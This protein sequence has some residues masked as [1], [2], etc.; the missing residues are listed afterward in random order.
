M[1]RRFALSSKISKRIAIFNMLFFAVL[2][3]EGTKMKGGDTQK[4]AAPPK[5]ITTEENSGDSKAGDGSSG[6]NGADGSGSDA[7]TAQVA[8]GGDGNNSSGASQGQ[9]V[10]G[11]RISIDG[12]GEKINS[13]DEPTLGNGSSDGQ[14]NT[15]CHKAFANHHGAPFNG[16]C[17]ESSCRVPNTRDDSQCQKCI[18]EEPC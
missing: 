3:C 1:G 16:R 10:N 8:G 2:A 18:Y 17:A 5:K 9:C 13:Q 7:N 12:R 11:K 14:C 4:K 15:S 6:A